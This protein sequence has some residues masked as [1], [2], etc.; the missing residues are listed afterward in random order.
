MQAL[1]KL[2][3]ANGS[4]TILFRTLIPGARSRAAGRTEQAEMRGSPN[5]PRAG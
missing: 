4:G 2:G 5:P 3:V 1:R